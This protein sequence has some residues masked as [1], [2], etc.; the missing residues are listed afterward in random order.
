[1]KIIIFFCFFLIPIILFP[2]LYPI[3]NIICVSQYGE[4]NYQLQQKFQ[5]VEGSPLKK[6][7]RELDLYLS[8][9]ER[10]EEYK[11]NFKPLDNILVSITEA[12]SEIAIKEKGFEKFF[13]VSSK[14]E[15]ISEA[16]ASALPKVFIGREDIKFDSFESLFAVKLLVELSKFYDI[17]E[18]TL[19]ESEIKAVYKQEIELIFPVE[20]DIDVL[21][22][23]L[24][25]L[26]FQ[27]KQ[28]LPDTTISSIDLRYKNV[29]VR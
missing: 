6:T 13:L 27:L 14:G 12:K 17:Q 25:L 10:I 4:C 15:L 1:M 7:L 5:E 9:N 3:R 24:E 2:F 18:V 20:A 23:S 16:S 26:L 21:L 28:K 8:E 22:G 11:V 19:S 29:I